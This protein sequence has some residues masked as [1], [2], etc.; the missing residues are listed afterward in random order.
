MSYLGGL[1]EVDGVV[2][3]QAVRQLRLAAPLQTSELEERGSRQQLRRQNH[4][5][6]T[7]RR[8]TGQS[9]TVETSAVNDRTSM[10]SACETVGPAVPPQYRDVIIV[11]THTRVML[12][13]HR[14]FNTKTQ[15]ACLTW[16]VL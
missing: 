15:E 4:R 3:R 12:L 10:A 1:V 14:H 16:K 11:C 6:R 13:T 5:R 7:V 8:V 9:P 2:R